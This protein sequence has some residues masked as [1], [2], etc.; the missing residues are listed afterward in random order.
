MHHPWKEKDVIRP[1][2]ISMGLRDTGLNFPTIH[3]RVNRFDPDVIRQDALATRVVMHPRFSSL[4]H[5]FL[6]HKRKFGSDN[7]KYLYSGKWGPDQQVERLIT[8]RP[9]T[10][11]GPDD[12]TLFRPFK[13]Y[14]GGKAFWDNVDSDYKV[15]EDNLTYDEIMLASLL[16]VSGPSYFI[17]NGR[18]GNRA[19]RGVPGTFE[20]RGII[21]GLV[22]PRFE[23]LEHMDANFMVNDGMQRRLHPDLKEK[24]EWFFRNPEPSDDK[25]N[26]N[27]YR[28]RIQ[29]SAEILLLEANQRAKDAGRKAYVYAVGLGLGVWKYN[30]EQP[31]HY[32]QAFS[33]SLIYLKR[34]LTDIATL[35]FAYITVPKEIRDEITEVGARRGITVKFS[36]REPADKL[37]GREAKQ[38]LVIS[39][40]WD[41]NSFPGNEYWEGSLNASGDPAAA[42]MSTIAELHNPLVNP[43]M[44][45][46]IHEGPYYDDFSDGTWLPVIS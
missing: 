29:V 1:T 11:V 9:L 35:E 3:N 34:F 16:A 36:K 32:I 6:L 38:L 37:Q 2:M 23:R 41:G 27:A 18:R 20:P 45:R 24:F 13:P 44:A 19:E 7:E 21:I 12:H 4:V 25:F 28:A 8:K 43:G 5:A 14:K 10:F 42:C 26:F 30:D 17:N 22:G 15:L 33:S 46:R 31:S 39:Y 40:P